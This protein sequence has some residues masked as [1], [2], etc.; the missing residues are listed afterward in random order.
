MITQS[1]KITKNPKSLNRSELRT[2]M[3]PILRQQIKECLRQGIIRRVSKDYTK[4]IS[5]VILME[6]EEGDYRLTANYS[7][8]NECI[9]ISSY[10]IPHIE[11]IFMKLGGMEWFSR[12]DLK[13]GSWNIP[14]DEESKKYTAF[15]VEP[16]EIY[17][18]NVLPFGMKCTTSLIQDTL[19]RIL[20]DE[21]E[22][23]TIAI[24]IDDILIMTKDEQ[25]HMEVLNNVLYALETNNM[26]INK[27]KS[28]FCKK[29]LMYLQQILGPDGIQPSP[30]KIK[31]IL[32]T[33][34]PKNLKELQSF[35]GTINYYKCY[36]PNIC[37]NTA[38]FMPLL[39][40]YSTFIWTNE[41][42]KAF[43]SIINKVKAIKPLAFFNPKY[44]HVIKTYASFNAVGGSL[45]Q[46]AKQNAG[47]NQKA[48]CV[49]NVSVLLNSKRKKW[50]EVEKEMYSIV[51][52]T[53]KLK[54]YLHPRNKQ[55]AR[56]VYIKIDQYKC[57]TCT[58][59]THTKSNCYTINELININSDKMK[60]WINKLLQ[61]NLIFQGV[62]GTD[63]CMAQ[64]ITKKLNVYT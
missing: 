17:I 22:K 29:S 3:I 20:K 21:L 15:E 48:R 19:E 52:V 32:E 10:R 62:D 6:K 56:Q 28:I 12:I 63:K 60:G 4:C 61:Y 59:L 8:V 27:S 9:D 38:E 31:K 23:G 34:P 46:F 2:W 45:I 36:L 40:A 14:L 26:K 7:Y 49:Q 43:E 5:P 11:E 55:N 25:S 44:T 42:T 16:D 50:T 54:N 30:E 13:N 41:H 35:L 24:Y 37:S 1:F 18:F 47:E 39:Q 58:H 64:W 53:D 33:S 51:A 57:R